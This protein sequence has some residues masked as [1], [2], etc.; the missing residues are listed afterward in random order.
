MI[1][2]LVLSRVSAPVEISDGVYRGLLSSGNMRYLAEHQLALHEL[3]ASMRRNDRG[4]LHK[5]SRQIAMLGT[6]M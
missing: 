2:K 1:Q 6:S 3:Y 4:V 5:I